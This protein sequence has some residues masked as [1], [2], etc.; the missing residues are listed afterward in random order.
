MVSEWMTLQNY[1][2]T[3]FKTKNVL[4]WLPIIDNIDIACI[5]FKETVK[6]SWK[7]ILLF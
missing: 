1:K 3:K 7:V 2:E 6:V 5:N 4:H